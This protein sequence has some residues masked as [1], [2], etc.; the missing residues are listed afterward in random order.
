MERGMTVLAGM[1]NWLAASGVGR[2]EKAVLLVL[3]GSRAESSLCSGEKG[4]SCWC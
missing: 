1:T 2:A 3:D 4:G